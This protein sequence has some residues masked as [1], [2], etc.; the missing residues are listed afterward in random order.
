MLTNFPLP[1]R[2]RRF[3]ESTIVRP[4]AWNC[5]RSPQW[6]GGLGGIG[7]AQS[8]KASSTILILFLLSHRHAA[9]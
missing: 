3:E 8:A 5:A 6:C 4:L 1:I 7:K 2:I 9:R